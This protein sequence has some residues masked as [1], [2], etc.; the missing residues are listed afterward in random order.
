MIV[1]PHVVTFLLVKWRSFLSEQLSSILFFVYSAQLCWAEQVNGLHWYSVFLVLMTTQIRC[2]SINRSINPIQPFKRT[3][4]CVQLRGNVGFII[5]SKHISSHGMGRLGMNCR[6]AGKRMTPST[7]RPTDSC[8]GNNGHLMIMTFLLKR[9]IQV[10]CSFYAWWQTAA[11]IPCH[12]SDLLLYLKALSCFSRAFS[13]GTR[14]G[15][16]FSV[17]SH[18][19]GYLKCPLV[20]KLYSRDTTI[21]YCS[22]TAKPYLHD[23]IW[24]FGTDSPV[25]AADLLF[26]RC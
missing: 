3:F 23:N 20:I 12:W 6:P 18:S 7:S 10:G 1:W 17:I 24:I 21:H 8:F 2:H 16:D 19:G 15:L 14:K 9:W 11:S 4:I 26:T 25:A 5:F 13:V 22:A